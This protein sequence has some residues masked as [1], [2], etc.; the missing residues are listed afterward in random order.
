[1]KGI[2]HPISKK[3]RYVMGVDVFIQLRY[4]VWVVVFMAQTVWAG[5]EVAFLPEVVVMPEVIVGDSIKARV[6]V[7]NVGNDDLLVSGHA[8]AQQRGSAFRATPSQFEVAVGDSVAIQITFSPKSGGMYTDAL[9]FHTNKTFEDVAQPIPAVAISGRVISPEIALSAHKLTFSSVGIGKGVTQHVQVS[10]VG[11]E[12][13]RVT[14]AFVNDRRFAVD[15]ATFDVPAS[16]HKTLAITYLPDSSRARTD[17]LII[18]S[19]DWDESR[20]GVLLDAF[21]TPRGE[22][23][24][25][26]SLLRLDTVAF[27][28]VGDT[29]SAAVFLHTN[30]DS[31]GGV[32]IYVG[33]NPLFFRSTRPD[34]PYV[35]KGLTRDSLKVLK[36]T[37]VTAD[38]T[39]R[40]VYLSAITSVQGRRVFDGVVAHVS[41]VVVSPLIG[42]TRLRTLTDITRLNSIYTTPSGRAF[43][44]PGSGGLVFGNTPPQFHILPLITMQED[45]STSL[46]LSSLAT[47]AESPASDLRW[48]FKDPTS[49]MKTTFVTENGEPKIQF[50][51]PEN[52]WG[53]YPI[54]AIVADS[55]GASDTTSVILQVSAV[56]DPPNVPELLAPSQG[57]DQLGVPVSF[58]WRASDVDRGDILTFN[59][60][61]AQ[62]S[63]LLAP[64]LTGLRDST[65]VYANLQDGKTYFWQISARDKT[66]VITRSAI[67]QFKMA[68]SQETGFRY[69]GDLNGDRF[70]GFADFVLFAQGFGKL[71]GQ[72]GFV[73]LADLD[74][75]GQI[76]FAD[77]IIFVRLFGTDYTS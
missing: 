63:L 51:P 41:F 38:D 58:V 5:P 43:T 22:G 64:V 50:L 27:P 25:R 61:L 68:A 31:V 16:G 37:I 3:I 59:F 42:Q 60:R 72:V 14:R 57:A 65:L 7:V 32:E 18:E 77:F 6:V 29:I 45:R 2:G 1:M 71:K 47:D 70:V 4:F 62:D 56:N 9:V 46:R 20:V 34:S 74:Q 35:R 40:A 26:L 23:R 76:G 52:G 12:V 30:Q 33:Y 66:G 67:R 73:L 17:S 55:A 44:L 8:F 75:D 54:S 36:N 28:V 69:V 10:N 21:G 11:T 13:L 53:T 39:R 24:A 15:A 48:F 19:N 49:L